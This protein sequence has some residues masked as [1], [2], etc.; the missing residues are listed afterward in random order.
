MKKAAEQGE[1]LVGRPPIGAVV[2]VEATRTSPGASGPTLGMRLRIVWRLGWPLLRG[3]GWIAPA[4]VVFTFA[5]RSIRAVAAQA[6]GDVMGLLAGPTSEAA[7]ADLKFAFAKW[8]VILAISVIVPFIAQLLATRLDAEMGRALRERLFAHALRQ[9]PEFYHRND[10]GRLTLLLNQ[11]AVEAQ[12]ALRMLIVDPVVNLTAAL[13][14]AYLIVTNLLR[15]QEGGVG[16]VGVFAV[17]VIAFL[18]PW[19]TMKLG[20]ALQRAS[21]AVRDQGMALAGLVTGA[22]QAPE[23]IQAMEAEPVFGSRYADALRAQ[24]GVRMRQMR[25]VQ[26]VNTLDD[27]P[28]HL[29]QIALFGLAIALAIAGHRAVGAVVAIT[30]QA[31]GLVSPIQMI[32]RYFTTL[33]GAWPSIEAVQQVLAMPAADEGRADAVAPA[34]LQPTLE[35]RDVEFAYPEGPRIFSGFTASFPP[36]KI[37]GLVARMGGGKTTLF[38]LVLGFYAQQGGVIEVGGHD[39][40]KVSLA[41]LRRHVVMMAQFPAWFHDSLRNNLRVADPTA[42]DARLRTLLESTGMWP[43]LVDKLGPNPLDAPFAGGLMLS[44]GQ[45]KLLALS[46]CLLREP[47]ILLLDEPTAG[48]D[49]EEKYGLVEPI[50]SACQGRTVVVVDHDVAW[51]MKFCDHFVVIDQGRN[52]QEGAAEPLL[53]APGLFRELAMMPARPLAPLLDVLRAH[54]TTI[55]LDGGPSAIAA[56]EPPRV[57]AIKHTE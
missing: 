23:E 48:M 54:S 47:S 35:V 38:R 53:K 43:L 39:T 34:T 8:V 30:G 17:C 16:K 41:S 11:T 1:V 36:Q 28:M 40:R 2:D 49:N 4:A 25:T 50:R 42:T 46:R 19:L 26:L 29:V 14:T 37:T 57:G 10:P 55:S 31:P 44:G 6:V 7:I 56:P 52:A 5:E 51:L 15:L 13:F 24:I 45:R 20:T 21:A 3:A 9:R 22:F 12:V 18:A 27:V 33:R 32:G